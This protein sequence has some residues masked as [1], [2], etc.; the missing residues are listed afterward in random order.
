M[1]LE[2]DIEFYGVVYIC[3]NCFNIWFNE[4]ASPLISTLRRD[5]G[6]AQEKIG[7]LEH[8]R[9]L[10]LGVIRAYDIPVPVDPNQ[11][12]LLDVDS[13]EESPRPRRY[14]DDFNES[15]SKPGPNDVLDFAGK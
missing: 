5:M 7:K 10:L 12:S 9:D 13:A 2:F 14:P 8:E 15:G 1:D 11:S 3:E 4:W 6:F